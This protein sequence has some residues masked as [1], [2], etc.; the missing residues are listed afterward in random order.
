MGKRV[1]ILGAGQLAK[2]L[3]ISAKRLGHF[4]TIVAQSKDDP[5]VAHADDANF[6]QW[7]PEL[8]LQVFKTH[9]VVTFENEWISDDLLEKVKEE[10]LIDR[11]VPGFDGM[12]KM[13]TK[14]DQKQFFNEQGYSSG[15]ALS[16][17]QVDLRDPKA[18][19]KLS[20]Q[21]PQGAVLK[22]SELAY[23]GK[24]VF[25]FDV[26][27]ESGFLTKALEL[28]RNKKAWY[29]EEKINFQKELALVFTRATDGEFCHLP[30]VEFKSKN[31]ICSSVMV[32]QPPEKD[33]IQKQNM[34]VEIAFDLAQKLQWCGTAAIEFF[35]TSKGELLINE[36]APRVHNS[37]HFSLSASQTSQFENHI[38]AVTGMPLGPCGT[39]Q[40]AY[41]R[42]LIGTAK[43]VSSAE[44]KSAKNVELFWYGKKQI[45]AGRKMGHING[46][47]SLAEKNE[48]IKK[49]DEIVENW[50]LATI[51][52]S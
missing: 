22:Q 3:A 7:T 20:E 42:N 29:L 52:N 8:F 31:G 6:S 28:N 46:V 47:G 17:T 25:V 11:M 32:Q 4:V 40:F 24:G 41:M 12:A 30:I 2:Y 27:S 18:I 1:A 39:A 36:F 49:V 16:G 13:R 15:R 10:Q 44:P 19:Q 48:I 35:L 33:L 23:D 5:A 26:M 21:F 45:R 43:S 38:R 37:G 14:W 50:E 34:A 9:D 51:L